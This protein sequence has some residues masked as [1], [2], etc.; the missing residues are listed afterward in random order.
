LNSAYAQISANQCIRSTL[1]DGSYWVCAYDNLGQA[2]SGKKH[3]P[4]N[5]AVAGQQFEYVFD[6]IETG[7]GSV[8]ENVMFVRDAVGP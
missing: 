6:D 7:K 3:W 8:R 4:D 1:A 2:T 5:S